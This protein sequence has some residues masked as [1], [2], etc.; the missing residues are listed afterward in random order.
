MK[1]WLTK[2]LHDAACMIAEKIETEV[3]TMQDETENSIAAEDEESE[4]AAAERAIKIMEKFMCDET[5]QNKEDAEDEADLLAIQTGI[6]FEPEAD[7]HQES[8][9]LNAADKI[10]R[11]VDTVAVAVAQLT[12]KVDELKSEAED[13]NKLLAKLLAAQLYKLHFENHLSLEEIE[14]VFLANVKQEKEKEA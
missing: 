4:K 2:W 13:R 14:N 6:G 3:K 1:T 8:H 9:E 7:A 10:A 11:S 5:N 12:R